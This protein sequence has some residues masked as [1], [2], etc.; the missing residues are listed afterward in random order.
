MALSFNRQDFSSRYIKLFC[1]VETGKCANI[2]TNSCQSF[3]VRKTVVYIWIT[4]VI[5]FSALQGHL[6]IIMKAVKLFN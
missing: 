6:P 2:V 3:Y 4:L 1:I 5:S